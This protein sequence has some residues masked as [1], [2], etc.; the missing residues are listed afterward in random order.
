MSIL[1]I[2]IIFIV[3]L[4]IG[5]YILTTELLPSLSRSSSAQV[6]SKE[7]NECSL[8]CLYAINFLATYKFCKKFKFDR[9]ELKLSTQHKNMYMYFL[10][11]YK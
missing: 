7:F 8:G 1:F 10:K 11:L 9:N 2:I 4:L 5:T 3:L 6:V